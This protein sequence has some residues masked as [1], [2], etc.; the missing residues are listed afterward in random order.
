MIE[1]V[2]N[3]NSI[4]TQKPFYM[5]ETHLSSLLATFFFLPGTWGCHPPKVQVTLC[6]MLLGYILSGEEGP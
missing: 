6:E 5:T 3:A 2:T 4:V 1:E